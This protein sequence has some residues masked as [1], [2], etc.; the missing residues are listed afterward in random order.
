[1]KEQIAHLEILPQV[2]YLALYV[3]SPLEI[4]RKWS[5]L[6]CSIFFFLELFGRALIEI[7]AYRGINVLF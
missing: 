7:L 2:L 5:E 3:L 1:M 6:F 4:F